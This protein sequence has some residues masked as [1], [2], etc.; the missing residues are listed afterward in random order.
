[1]AQKPGIKSSYL[2]YILAALVFILGLVFI[3]LQYTAWNNVKEEIRQEEE[4][5]DLAG[6][7][8]A[9][10]NRHRENAPEYEQ[11]LAVARSLIPLQPDEDLLINY[12]Y[13][14]AEESD[15]EV[16]MIRF[17]DHSADDQFTTIPMTVSFDGTYPDLR[18]FLNQL[19]YGERAI[20]VNS[21]RINRSGAAESG[22]SVLMNIVAFYNNSE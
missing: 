19:Y 4:A 12:L 8:L 2:I 9:L 6:I 1:M 3:Y 22:I 7:Q 21:I 16:N 20:R 14:L 11:R 13:R 18:R 17:E 5:L 10:L 15:L